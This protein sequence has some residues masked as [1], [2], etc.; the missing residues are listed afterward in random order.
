MRPRC[1][2]GTG[3]DRRGRRDPAPAVP[4]PSK[5][6][7]GAYYTALTAQSR[8]AD[9]FAPGGRLDG[10]ATSRPS[11]ALASA[12]IGPGGSPRR[13]KWAVRYSRPEPPGR[14]SQTDRPRKGAYTGGVVNTAQLA[15]AA[16]LLGVEREDRGAPRRM[17]EA[18]RPFAAAVRAAS[19][20]R[21][22]V[23]SGDGCGAAG[24]GA[25]SPI[26]ARRNARPGLEQAAFHPP[27]DAAAR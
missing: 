2:Y 16:E 24:S 8:T 1:P 20:A 23:S 11:G 13:E 10:S 21:A 14:I 22:A 15:A 26:D 3:G 17:R 7:Y 5:P 19:L 25:G 12:R 6:A 9:R 4:V 18:R 27:V